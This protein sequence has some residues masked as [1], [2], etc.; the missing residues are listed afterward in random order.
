MNGLAKPM[1]QAGW[2]CNTSAEPLLYQV[3]S[4]LFFVAETIVSLTISA[5]IASVRAGYSLR[6]GSEYV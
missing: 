5:T 1:R 6:A 4:D 3:D 2:R